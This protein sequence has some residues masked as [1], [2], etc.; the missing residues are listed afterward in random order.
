MVMGM[1]VKSNF[2]TKKLVKFIKFT[3]FDKSIEMKR[4][5]KIML[6]ILLL[7]M[8]MVISSYILLG[9]LAIYILVCEFIIIILMVIGIGL[10]IQYREKLEEFSDKLKNSS[11]INKVK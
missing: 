4:F 10:Y 8:F 7:G 1:G 6:N 5:R 3:L 9:D 2:F 11:L